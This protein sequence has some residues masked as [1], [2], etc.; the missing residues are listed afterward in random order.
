MDFKSFDSVEQ[1]SHSSSLSNTVDIPSAR[2]EEE[3][4]YHPLS[5]FGTSPFELELGEAGT[6]RGTITPDRKSVV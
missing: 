5:P 1:G 6:G 4:L 3:G 2:P